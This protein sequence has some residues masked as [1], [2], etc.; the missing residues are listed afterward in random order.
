VQLT[1]ADQVIEATL[2]EEDQVIARVS[3]ATLAYMYREGLARERRLEHHRGDLWFAASEEHD[4]FEGMRLAVRLTNTE[5]N[6]VRTGSRN[7]RLRSEMV[8]READRR[9]RAEAPAWRVPFALVRV[10]GTHEQGA[11]ASREEGL[12]GLPS[13]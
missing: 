3:G 7:E 8:G 5:R 12:R 4:L 1:L 6:I 13:G 2:A 10:D 9:A 11:A